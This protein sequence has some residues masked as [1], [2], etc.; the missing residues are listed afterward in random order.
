M[1]FAELI[2]NKEFEKNE[3][4][5]GY[6]QNIVALRNYVTKM[7]E[8]QGKQEFTKDDEANLEVAIIKR[9]KNGDIKRKNDLNKVRDAVKINPQ[10]VHKF[11]K[12]STISTQKFFLETDAK[13]AYHYRN[14]LTS[15]SYL[16]LH[17]RTVIG[18]GQKK[19]FVGNDDDIK[20][21]RKAQEVIDEL[22]GKR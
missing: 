7:F 22:L 21:L 6:A 14:A 1:G 4:A 11:I 3:I 10:A 12:N 17:A 16:V 8:K 18:L 20:A 9:I 5:I 15:A 13:A 19:M 2:E